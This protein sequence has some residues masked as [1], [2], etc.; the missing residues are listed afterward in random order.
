MS[1]IEITCR[2]REHGFKALG[3]WIS[4]DGPVMKE[5]AERE[6]DA[7]RCF[8][9]VRHLLCDNRVALKHRLRLLSSCVVSS[10]YWCVGS[11][12]LTRSHSAPTF[13]HCKVPHRLIHVPRRPKKM[14]SHVCRW[15]R[16][17]R[18]CRA[19]H[20]LPQGDETYFASYF[21]WCG[22]VAWMAVT[23]PMRETSRV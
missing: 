11:L 20:K 14:Q 16:L 1:D 19:K 18:N 23:D 6:V 7:W 21:S 12:I 8:Y 2:Q 17:P 10:M 22:H 15:A 3:V 9:S 4:F 5:L 13:G